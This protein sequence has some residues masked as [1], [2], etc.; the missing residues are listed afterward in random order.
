M[1]KAT[2]CK[3]RRWDLNSDLSGSKAQTLIYQTNLSL[4]FL[5]FFQRNNGKTRT[6]YKTS[7][8]LSNLGSLKDILS[9]AMNWLTRSNEY[10]SYFHYIILRNEKSIEK[11]SSAWLTGSKGQKHNCNQLEQNNTLRTLE[12]HR[13]KKKV[14]SN[15]EKAEMLVSC[16]LKVTRSKICQ[17]A[18][19]ECISILLLL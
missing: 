9:T 12:S 17:K 16:H 3:Q 5:F 7:F 15:E 10:F 1:S 19:R 13:K 2:A 6:C 18:A 4:F 11:W 8:I 14:D